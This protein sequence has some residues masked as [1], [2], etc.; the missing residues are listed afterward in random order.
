MTPKGEYIRYCCLLRDNEREKYIKWSIG[1]FPLQLDVTGVRSDRAL[2][3]MRGLE[4][5]GKIGNTVERTNLRKQN[6]KM[7]CAP[8]GGGGGDLFLVECLSLGNRGGGVELP[9]CTHRLGC[10][11]LS[12]VGP[13]GAI[14]HRGADRRKKQTAGICC[15]MA[16]SRAE[17]N[18]VAALHRLR[19]LVTVGRISTA[20]TSDSTYQGTFAG[21]RL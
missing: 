18:R 6:K 17:T 21:I 10:T 11:K 19:S 16:A 4:G 14:L 12:F 15:C 5:G 3:N 13:A 1:G 2:C 8:C 7:A 20:E 9:R